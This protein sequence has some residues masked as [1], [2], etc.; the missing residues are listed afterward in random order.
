MLLIFQHHTSVKHMSVCPT[1]LP[2]FMSPTIL[3]LRSMDVPTV[4]DLNF[5]IFGNTIHHVHFRFL[6]IS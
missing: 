2:S 1:F 3:L 6:R 5:H 4:P